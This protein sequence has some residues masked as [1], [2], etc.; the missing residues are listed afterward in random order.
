MASLSAVGAGAVFVTADKA[1]ASPIVYS[2][3]LDV[4][5]G[6]TTKWVPEKLPPVTRTLLYCEPLSDP[7]LVPDY[8]E[9]EPYLVEP[10]NQCL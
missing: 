2:G 1:E 7:D 8:S 5:V 3:P 4:Q 6:W 9:G 10:A